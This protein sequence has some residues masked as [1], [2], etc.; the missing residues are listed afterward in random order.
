MRKY[1]YIIIQSTEDFYFAGDV[2]VIFQKAGFTNAMNV[3]F[4]RNGNYTS[5]KAQYY[6]ITPERYY[7]YSSFDFGA[8]NYENNRKNHISSHY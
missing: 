3:T 5:A 1:T 6:T 2:D 8:E 4:I 7:Y